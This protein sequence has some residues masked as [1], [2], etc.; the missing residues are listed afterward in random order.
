LAHGF[1]AL[2]VHLLFPVVALASDDD[3]LSDRAAIQMAVRDGL[4]DIR[5]CYEKLLPAHPELEGK[6]VLSWS[7][8]KGG[9]VVKVTV[10]ENKVTGYA[11]G[12]LAICC[13]GVIK[14][15]RFPAPPAGGVFEIEGY[16]FQ[17]S[18]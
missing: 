14:E 5:S 12:Q 3:G 13:M 10:K 1:C 9:K 17:F 16:P 6:L 11:A 4:K 2:L 7:I 18:K 8:G 15:I